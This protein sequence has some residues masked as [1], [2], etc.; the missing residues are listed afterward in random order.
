MR[1]G[2]QVLGQSSEAGKAGEHCR[3]PELD[4]RRLRAQGRGGGRRQ[5]ADGHTTASSYGTIRFGW[6]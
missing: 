4:G 6:V 2:L 1:T 3:R 5:V